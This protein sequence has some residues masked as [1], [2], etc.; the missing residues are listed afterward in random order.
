MIIVDTLTF[1]MDHICK[2]FPGMAE[3]VIEKIDLQSL[4]KFNEASREGSNFLDKGRVLWKQ[5]ILKK[6]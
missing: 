5:M 2:R 3:E 6:I 4:T 1:K